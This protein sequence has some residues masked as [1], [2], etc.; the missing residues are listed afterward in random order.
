MPS[1]VKSLSYAYFL[2][3]AVVMVVYLTRTTPLFSLGGNVAYLLLALPFAGAIIL[4]VLVEPIFVDHAPVLLR[5]KRQFMFDMATYLLIAAGLFTVQYLG[6]M[7]PA[8]DSVK[9]II[10]ALIIG[11][12]ASIDNALTRERHWFTENDHETNK[13]FAF[14]SLTSRMS[15]FLTLTVFIAMA[16]TAAVAFIDL[17]GLVEASDA[18]REEVLQ[19]F[20]LDLFFVFC[21][22]LILTCVLFIRI[23]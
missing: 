6:Y 1:A 2:I 4:K 7:V 17:N 8:N 13:E 3:C 22:V 16:A 18:Q 5:P 15:L 19:L 20:A 11:Y 9:I 23:H 21:V 10:A 12:F 14:S